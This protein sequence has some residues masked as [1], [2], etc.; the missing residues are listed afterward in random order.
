LRPAQFLV[1]H[2]QLNLMNLQ[3]MQQLLRRF[4]RQ[5]SECLG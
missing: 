1:L 5:C 3:V 2:L 4:R